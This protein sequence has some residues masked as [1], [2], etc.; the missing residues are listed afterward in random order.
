MWLFYIFF[1]K[2]LNSLP[3]FILLS[4]HIFTKNMSTPICHPF[5]ESGKD[6]KL[7]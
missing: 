2:K 1:Y 4:N 6:E 3:F 5:I 7:N